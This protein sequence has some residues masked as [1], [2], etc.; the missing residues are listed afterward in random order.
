M[1][2]PYTYPGIQFNGFFK[3]MIEQKKK[4]Q[5][6]DVI[7][8]VCDYFQIPEKVFFSACRTDMVSDA[9]KAVCYLA[10][11]MLKRNTCDIGKVIN[12]DHSTVMHSVKVCQDLM[13]TDEI[14][15]S[16]IYYLTSKLF[17]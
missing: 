11:V 17:K 8:L 7:T 14:Y 1:I 12:R 2:S 16:D 9:R 10:N 5:L 6:L 3:S 15:A 4:K 13:I